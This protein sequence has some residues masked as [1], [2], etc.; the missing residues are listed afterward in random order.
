[1]GYFVTPRLR[2]MALSSGQRTHGGIDLTITSRATL[3][4]EQF[5]HHDQITRDIALNVGA[6]V[7]FSLTPTVDVYSSWLRTV[8]Q[9]NGHL[10]DRGVTIGM[11]WS[12]ST[13]RAVGRGIA[14][15]EEKSL[16]RCVCEKAGN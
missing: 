8:T 4:P 14:S 13:R 3:P 2:L 1:V 5:L 11:S 16:T 7:S 9:R 15:L 6:G 12:F 10:L